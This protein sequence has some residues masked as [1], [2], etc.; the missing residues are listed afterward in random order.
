MAS[1][2]RT[3]TAGC[4]TRP[5]A[6]RALKRSR[7]AV[8]VA[9]L[10]LAATGCSY[11]EHIGGVA[12]RKDARAA[13]AK[14]AA[15]T[16][17]I[18]AMR[19]ADE[20]VD[21]VA[22]ATDTLAAALPEAQSQIDIL[23]WQFSQA[24]AAVQIVSG[25]K[26]GSSA[27]DMVVLTSL[28]RRIVARDWVARYG[29]LARPVLHAYESLEKEA[30]RLAGDSTDEQRAG[31]NALLASW[32]SDNPEIQNPSFVRFADFSTG[33]T[34]RSVLAIP[35]LLDLVGLD[36]LAGLD[37]AVRE[38]EQTR[39]LAE[40]AVFYAERVPRLLDIQGRLI[41]ARARNSPAGR[42]AL[43]AVG[44]VNG[45]SVSLTQLANGAPA[46]VTRERTAAIDQVMSELVR[47]QREMLA[48][49]TQLRAA[50]EAGHLTADSLNTLVNSTDRLVARFTPATPAPPRKEPGPPF[51]I[52]D[53]T[54]ALVQ[55]SGS[56]QELQGLVRDID[57]ATPQ[58]EVQANAFAER[59]K[60]LIAY[61]IG[62]LAL[63]VLVI[64]V[65]ALTYRIAARR[66]LRA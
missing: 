38:V 36:P 26:S 32:V 39:Q 17:Q 19:F 30:W 7:W 34:Q 18:A 51:D 52:N 37:P 33:E 59:I 20:Y 44:N 24:T 54:K 64:L 49:A 27:V 43:E 12:S 1:N 45:L 13:K 40:R 14:D 42:Q 46:L 55:L 21:R 31:L 56:A 9:V 15:L 10:A 60:G 58:I 23:D 16:S 22:R 4:D 50:I 5:A 35:G 8:A 25:P 2:L 29:E 41:A 63:L 62:G 57:H 61:A 28:S 48:L 11:L 3:R 47:Q 66:I 53:Y 6:A 65:A